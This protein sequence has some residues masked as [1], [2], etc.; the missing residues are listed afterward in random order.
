MAN[1][2]PSASV[3]IISDKLQQQRLSSGSD[4]KH[5]WFQL[6]PHQVPTSGPEI[7]SGAVHNPKQDCQLV[8]P[9]NPSEAFRRNFDPSTV[10]TNLKLQHAMILW[11]ESWS[12]SMF[13]SFWISFEVVP[14]Q[15]WLKHV[16][17]QADA[18]ISVS[19]DVGESLG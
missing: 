1:P 12:A 10:G 6:S 17:V 14:L 13:H 8:V 2:L 5:T 9:V 16:V 11:K 7:P 4:D 18:P 15:L 19:A 3:R